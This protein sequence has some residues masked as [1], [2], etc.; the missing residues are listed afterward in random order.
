[1]T[2]ENL[3]WERALKHFTSVLDQYKDLIGAPGVN[4]MFALS[5]MNLTLERYH[6]GERTSELYNEMME[7]E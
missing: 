2:E 3:D 7:A 1:M 5:H 6:E 4:V